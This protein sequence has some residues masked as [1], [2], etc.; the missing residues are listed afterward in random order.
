[1][2]S[3]L[4][5]GEIK[6]CIKVANSRTVTRLSAY[7]TWRNP[8]PNHDLLNWTRT[9]RLL[10]SGETTFTP[11]LVVNAFLFSRWE[12]VQRKQTDGQGAYCG[13]LGRPHNKLSSDVPGSLRG[14]SWTVSAAETSK[15]TSDNTCP[16]L[17]R[18]CVALCFP[19]TPKL[20]LVLIRLTRY[21][22][23]GQQDEHQTQPNDERRWR[24]RR[25]GSGGLPP[26]STYSATR[27][28]GRPLNDIATVAI[29]YIRHIRRQKLSS[30][31][32]PCYTTSCTHI[33]AQTLT[34]PHNFIHQNLEFFKL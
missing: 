1:V 4:Y 15:A 24:Q 23:V 30:F 2:L 19:R 13:L 31:H 10:L 22:D 8:R 21:G 32:S 12:S 5:D 16:F 7:T 27:R 33:H 9:H 11:T 3:L 14:A 28:P 25:S 29:H 17:T 6:M 20:P 18:P 26:W 34:K